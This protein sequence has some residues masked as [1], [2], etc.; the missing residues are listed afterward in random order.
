GYVA[1][2]QLGL[3]DVWLSYPG[4]SDWS[5]NGASFWQIKDLRDDL[6]ARLQKAKDLAAST[7][8]FGV[9]VTAAGYSI[10][11]HGQN[12][13]VSFD[14]Q[15]G[16]S[17]AQ[18]AATIIK[19]LAGGY[20]GVSGGVPQQL[21]SL[22][23]Q[24]AHDPDFAATLAQL[25]PPDTLADLL[26]QCDI[27]WTNLK[28]SNGDAA[29][30]EGQ[31]SQLVTGLGQTMSLGYTSLPA[32]SDAR[33]QMLSQWGDIYA[34]YAKGDPS[35]APQ[36][37]SMII[38]RGQWPDEFLTG[39]TDAIKQGEGPLGAGYWETSDASTNLPNPRPLY[40]PGLTGTDGGPVAVGD[41]MFGVWSAAVHNPEWFV[42]MYQSGGFTDIQ[43]DSQDGSSHDLSG[44]VDAVLQD[45]LTKRGVDVT[46]YLALL[47]A[48]SVA[49]S[50][51]FFHGGIVAS[52]PQVL[53]ITGEL[54]RNQRLYDEL[55]WWTKHGHQVLEAIEA[56]AAI[57]ACATG[58]GT[59][60]GVVLL[61]TVV[62]AGVV[63]ISWY[64]ADGD[65]RDAIINTVFLVFVM[66]DG[67]ARLIPLSMSEAQV[68]KA[69]GQ[70]A[71]RDGVVQ[72]IDGKAV[73]MTRA[74]ALD[75]PWSDG[76]PTSEVNPQMIT[77]LRAKWDIPSR[78]T[79]AVGKTDI[80]GL[81]GYRFEGGSIQVRRDAGL[82][83]LTESGD[84]AISAPR[85]LPASGLD[86]GEGDVLAK[87]DD[88]IAATGQT[89]QDVKGTVNI[90]QSK[91]SG[92]CGFCRAGLPENSTAQSDGVIKQ[93]SDKYPGVE[94]NIYTLNQDGTTKLA[95]SVIDG[96]YR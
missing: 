88:A 87:I 73:M 29:K 65:I 35:L 43:Y 79:V 83:P 22:L 31:Y 58:V 50:W 8:G 70:V 90:I 59:P 89:P 42:N 32:D 38:A 61:G 45:L 26:R 54:Q 19:N 56:V 74:E 55:P 37:L 48:A 11:L 75:R 78:D 13:I 60:L 9:T 52:V 30:F 44:Q 96:H 64:G 36:F 21:L 67:V 85:H 18:T 14:D 34:T 71:L 41:P 82:P 77:D 17:N 68:L 63:D 84:S 94:I 33:A 4:L 95:A 92:V 91:S 39:I 20:P 57:A 49:D 62:T 53:D 86:N 25:V 66:V 2:V 1:S 7:P 6:A 28:T 23:D 80:P 24:G 5:W 81:E 93:F 69:G 51:T 12:Y 72:I 3:G 46:S 16:A 40:D 76:I 27:Q 15:L 10:D 47:Q